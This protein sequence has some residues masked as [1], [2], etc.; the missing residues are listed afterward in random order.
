MKRTL[1][2]AAILG[3]GFTACKKEES[4]NPGNQTTEEKIIGIWMGDE[5]EISITAPPPVGN[6][7]MKEDISYLNVE[8][9]SDGTA[10][11][12][13]AGFDPDIINWSITANNELDLDGEIFEIMKLDASNFHFGF[14]DTD[15]IGTVPVEFS[16][17]IKLKK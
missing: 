7:T 5:Q 4:D 1:V 11:A 10:T 3:I 9:K 6:Q 17:L 12:D 2:L 15:T 13:S 16:T 14:S 8:F